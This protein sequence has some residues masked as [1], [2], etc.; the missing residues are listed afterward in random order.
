M[1]TE[2]VDVAL[3]TSAGDYFH[4][5]SVE[6]SKLQAAVAKAES[7]GVVVSLVSSDSA[8]LVVPWRLVKKVLYLSVHEEDCEFSAWNVL[9]QR[10][11]E[12]RTVEATE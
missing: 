6:M 7:D 2:L 3:E 5:L 11:V 9:Y 12:G 1:S 8:A 10:P 4:F